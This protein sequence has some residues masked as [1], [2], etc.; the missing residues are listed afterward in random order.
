MSDNQDNSIM[1]VIA[2]LIPILTGVLVYIMYNNNKRLKFHAIQAIILGIA[3][4]FVD[5]I[6]YII[7]FVIFPPI[8]Y[9][10]SIIEIILWVYG[11]YIGYKASLGTDISIK[12]I[13]DYASSQSGFQ[14]Q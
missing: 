11:L 4:L 5:I 9:A 13:G 7:S 2:Y 8:F 1:Y 10:G 6:F 12:Y 3:I 14:K